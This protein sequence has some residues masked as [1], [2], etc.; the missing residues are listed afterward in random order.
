MGHCGWN[1]Q[2]PTDADEATKWESRDRKATAIIGLGL[3]DAYLH[4]IDLSKKFKFHLDNI[5]QVV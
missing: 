2:K 4:H 5:E 1:I 3:S